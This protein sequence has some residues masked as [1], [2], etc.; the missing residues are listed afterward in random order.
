[1]HKYF[2]TVDGEERVF[3][4][5]VS[6]VVHKAFPEFN[7]KLIVDKYY[8]NWAVNKDSKYFSLIRY[9]K[10]VL[11]LGDAEIK[12]EIAGSWSAAGKAAST[13][14]TK[15]HLDVELWLNGDDRCDTT[16]EDMAKY[17]AW[18][19][20][21]PDWTPFR[22]EWSVYDEEACIA[23]QIDSLWRDG[24]GD[25]HMVDWKRCRII[26]PEARE[27]GFPPFHHLPHSNLG[28]YSVQQARLPRD[29]GIQNT[30][31]SCTER[32]RAHPAQVLWN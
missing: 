21:V 14:G 28:H 18:R 7:A 13:A 11:G 6:G 19:A 30:T 1:V 3:T 17:H 20:S 4:I 24:N 12:A 10:H 9:L 2:I 8:D 16:N 27:K 23:G 5:S 32:I 22:T 25:Y 29:F 31:D 26:E 15:T